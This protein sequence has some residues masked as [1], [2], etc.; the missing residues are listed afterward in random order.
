MGTF[1]LVIVVLCSAVDAHAV[2]TDG[3]KYLLGNKQ[4]LAP[5]PIGLAVFMAHVRRQERTQSTRSTTTSGS[6]QPP[7]SR[8]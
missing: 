7:R 5:I 1:L 3:E 8:W 2:T 4:N 6:R